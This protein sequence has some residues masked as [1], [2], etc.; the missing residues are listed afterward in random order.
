MGGWVHSMLASMKQWVVVRG[1]V[2]Q[3][4]ERGQ[5]KPCTFSGTFKPIKLV[6]TTAC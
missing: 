4:R 5:T 6:D 3:S 2:S 1:G